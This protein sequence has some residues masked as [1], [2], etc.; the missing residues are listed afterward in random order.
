M[1]SGTLSG[2]C[3]VISPLSPRHGDIHASNTCRCYTYTCM[4]LFSVSVKDW[5]CLLR[6]GEECEVLCW[7]WLSVCLCL[8]APKQATMKLRLKNVTSHNASYWITRMIYK[9]FPDYQQKI[10]WLSLTFHV[11][12]NPAYISRVYK[13][14]ERLDQPWSLSAS[15]PHTLI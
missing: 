7:T 2:K 8:S 11:S 6:P 9:I 5:W 14:Q 15:F 12:G 10:L 13:G 1:V 3:G 4:V